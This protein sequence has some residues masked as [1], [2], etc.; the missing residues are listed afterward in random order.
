MLVISLAT[1]GV[2]IDLHEFWFYYDDLLHCVGET[3]RK[4]AFDRPILPS[5]WHVQA[6]TNL[7]QI[8]VVPFEEL[9]F[10]YQ[11]SQDVPLS[12]ML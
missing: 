7:T 12:I 4:Y 10:C 9:V 2:S 6:W 3:S 1:K 5:L 8:E 11:R